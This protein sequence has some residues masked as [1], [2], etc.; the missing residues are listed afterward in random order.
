VHAHAYLLGFIAGFIS[1]FDE[2]ETFYYHLL[3]SCFTE[4]NARCF[5]SINYVVTCREELVH[6]WL[7]N[8]HFI[9]INQDGVL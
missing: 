1:L 4:Y 5:I 9:I 8:K 6:V 7:E 2:T 3:F